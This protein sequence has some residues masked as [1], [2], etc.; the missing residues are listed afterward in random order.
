MAEWQQPEVSGGAKKRE[1]K[2]VVFAA[3]IA[4]GM[5]A[6]GKHSDAACNNIRQMI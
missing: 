3:M 2:R 5:L 1:I 4:A 6:T